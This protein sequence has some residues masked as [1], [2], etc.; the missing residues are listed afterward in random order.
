MWLSQAVGV[1]EGG[2]HRALV[3]KA[4]EGLLWLRWLFVFLAAKLLKSS[5]NQTHGIHDGEQCGVLNGE[6]HRGFSAAA[7]TIEILSF[8]GC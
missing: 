5:V 8:K 1:A 4:M 2:N 7:R 3:A 6:S